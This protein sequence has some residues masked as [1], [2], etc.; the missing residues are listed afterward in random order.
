[1]E[2]P[3][4][5]IVM[6]V[7]NATKYLKDSIDSIL[8]QS[9][10]DFELIIVND[11]STDESLDIIKKYNDLRIVVINNSHNFINSLNMGIT[12]AKGKYIARMDADDIMMPDRLEIQYRF[13][14]KNRHIDICGGWIHTFGSY[15]RE[16]Q[17][18]QQSK[19]IILSAIFH[20]PLYH[21]TIMMRKEIRELFEYNDEIYQ[22]YN[23]EYV[24]AEDYK[25][26]TDLLT[27]KCKFENIPQILVKYRVSET[28]V[29]SLFQ[30]E[31][32]MKTC[33]I[34]NEYLEII[35]AEIIKINEKYYDIL[36]N[37]IDLY[38]SSKLSFD[39]LKMIVYS[40]GS[41]VSDKLFEKEY[42]GEQPLI[43]IVMPVYN[44]E[45]FVKRSN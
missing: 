43:S 10:S 42:K 27:K 39:N 29:T 32:L 6:P 21:P 13:L 3:Q 41:N 40:I 5:S 17:T 44:V 37:A 33:K 38:N 26:W 31:M 30:K 45:E 11:G 15:E 20:C 24:Y 16:M 14:E 23:E 28:Q 22:V 35:M 7:Y 8:S 4:I 9:F 18:K 2:Q 1:M 34:Q 36:D 25:L 19:D 12:A